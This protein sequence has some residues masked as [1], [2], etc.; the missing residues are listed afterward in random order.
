MHFLEAL[1]HAG[2]QTLNGNGAVISATPTIGDGFNSRPGTSRN[3]FA[4]GAEIV[5]RF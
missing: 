2:E 1:T 3:M 5:H 4:T